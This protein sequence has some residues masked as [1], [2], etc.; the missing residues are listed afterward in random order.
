MV[1]GALFAWATTGTYWFEVAVV[2][3]LIALVAQGGDLLESS[4]KRRFHV[5]D[6][7]T[8]IPGHGGVL[9]RLDG[10]MAASAIAAL[11]TFQR[12][13]SVFVW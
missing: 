5:K 10:V 3:A 12:G 2:S 1:V 9:D 13:Q 7:S 8:L 11:V 4:V 6:A